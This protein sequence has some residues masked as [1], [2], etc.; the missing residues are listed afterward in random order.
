MR[1]LLVGHVRPFDLA[2]G[3][4]SG[5]AKEDVDLLSN[6]EMAYEALWRCWQNG[7]VLDE[8]PP[9]L[10]PTTREAG[11]AIQAYFERYSA[12]PRVGW[13]IAATSAAGQQHI[14]VAGPMAGRLL[15]E[16]IFEDGASVPVEGNRMRVCEPE[17]AFR[18]AEDMPPQSELFSASEVMS[19]VAH[20][21]L[22]I[23]LPDF[24]LLGFHPRR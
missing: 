20:L 9:G 22:T 15:A 7:E 16:R 18:F 8:L 11:Y 17:F 23:E 13:K 3:D 5:E 24:P 6:Q 14:N 1:L 4:W 10:K 12:S 21:H 19:N 2:T